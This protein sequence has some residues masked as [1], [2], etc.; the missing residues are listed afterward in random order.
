[1]ATMSERERATAVTDTAVADREAA[2]RD[3]SDLRPLAGGRVTERVVQEIRG[4]IDTNSLR[5]G[6]KL[7]PERFFIEQLGVSRSSL[8]EA[9]RVL[10]TL[11]LV[12]VRHGDGTYV[13][14]PPEDWNASSPAIFDATEENALRNLVE[15][16]LG[17]ELAAATAATARASEADLGRLAEF[18]NDQRRRLAEDPAF[19]WEPLGFELAMVEITGNTWLYEVEVMLR[20]AWLSLSGGL[21]ASVG[22]H[23]EW[24]TEHRAILASMRSRNALQVQRLVMAHLS[25][26]RFEEDLRTQRRIPAPAKRGR[27]SSSRGRSAT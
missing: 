6:H 23:D 7:P 10:S 14:A 16:R 8:R 5:A 24:L 26:E 2:R 22:R 18:L 15:T 4:Y 13:T 27:A 1:M 21:R 19:T 17:I 3:A 12:E 9:M 25:L 11:G 20:D